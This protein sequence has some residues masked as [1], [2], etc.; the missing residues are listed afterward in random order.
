MEFA[1]LIIETVT[2]EHTDRRQRT[3][4]RLTF[5]E[6]KMQELQT[7]REDLS[8]SPRQ[9]L[10]PRSPPDRRAPREDLISDGLLERILRKTS[11]ST[12]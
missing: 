4:A 6:N 10:A 12:W 3:E 9:G 5:L 2:S 1:S 11:I 8:R 7:L